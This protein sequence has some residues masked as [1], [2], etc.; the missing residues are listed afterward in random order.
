[1]AG[2]GKEMAWRRMG[3]GESHIKL[4][5]AVKDELQK[6]IHTSN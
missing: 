1:M 3:C 4:L 6:N 2:M 5:R